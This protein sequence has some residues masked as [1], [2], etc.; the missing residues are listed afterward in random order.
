MRLSTRGRLSWIGACNPPPKRRSKGPN[1]PLVPDSITCTSTAGRA[2]PAP[3]GPTTSIP[4]LASSR[5]CRW[6]V[7]AWSGCSWVST[8]AATSV[9]SGNWVKLPGSMIS[10]TPSSSSTTQEWAYL[11][12]RIA[13]SSHRGRTWDTSGRARPVPSG[14]EQTRRVAVLRRRRAR[15]SPAVDGG[16]LHRA[17]GHL[18][19]DS[20]ALAGRV[21][22][23]YAVSQAL[24]APQLAKLVDWFGQSRVMRKS[25]AVALTALVVLAVA[26]WQRAPEAVL[27]V[28]AALGGA[29]A[30]SDRKS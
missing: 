22:A 17:H 6:S 15:P 14:S 30:G 3:A 18:V 27:Y 26:G 29:M 1:R 23:V 21:S 13:G 8:T 9:N 24:C 25:L 4:G 19:Y 12:S 20:Y 7:P 28:T 5:A 11:V 10:R 2:A 16:H